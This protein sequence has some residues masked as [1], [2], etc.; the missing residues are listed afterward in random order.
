[1]KI[2]PKNR[3]GGVSMYEFYVEKLEEI[4]KTNL[5]QRGM[6][7]VSLAHQLK[8]GAESLFRGDTVFIVTGFVIR[9]TLT[10]ETDGPIGAI[11][12][13]AALEELGKK[14]IFI[15]DKYSKEILKEG[16]RVR[17]VKAPIEVIDH[18]MEKELTEGL[19]EKYR[20]SHI[21]AIERPG[22]S[23]D[24]KCYSMRG[25]DLS[26]IVPNVD[27]LFQRAKEIGIATIAIGDGGNE[28]GMGK[29]RSDVINSVYRGEQ[30]CSVFA[31][32]F[33]IIA[34][35]SNWGGH[36]LVAVLSILA[37]R[38]LLHDV[39]IEILLIK[40]IVEV[41]AVDGCTKKRTFT[42]DGLSLEENISIFL[43]LNYILQKALK[44]FCIKNKEAISKGA[45]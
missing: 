19:L 25:E 45:V 37:Q 20:P 9:D 14:V 39:N 27:I 26:D 15:T 42:V 8:K 29:V 2:I 28:I 35:V 6:E 21:V 16:S 41:G 1:M 10:G 11:S 22:A 44:S 33:L 34:G 5:E 24:G 31:T 30:I 17:G 40:R 32:D 7:K 4:I 3:W 36:A 43:K 18:N 13:G 38:C 12:L 23:I